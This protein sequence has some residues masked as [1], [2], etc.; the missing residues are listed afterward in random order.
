MNPQLQAGYAGLGQGAETEITQALLGRGSIAVDDN[1]DRQG[2]VMPSGSPGGNVGGGAALLSALAGSGGSVAPPTLPTTTPVNPQQAAIK[3]AGQGLQ[4][5]QQMAA[6]SQRSSNLNDAQAAYQD[7]MGSYARTQT[8]KFR[9]GSKAHGMESLYDAIA[10]PFARK[11]AQKARD[12]YQDMALSNE[13]A[14]LQQAQDLELQRRAKYVENVTPYI[15]EMNPGMT[16]QDVS[17]VAMQAA[18]QNTPVDKFIKERVESPPVKET[19]IHSGAQWTRFRNPETGAVLT[20]PQ[21]SPYQSGLPNKKTTGADSK[22]VPTVIDGEEVLIE[23]AAPDKDGKRAVIG[24]P[25]YTGK[26]IDDGGK[27]IQDMSGENKKFAPIIANTTSLVASA[28]PH[29]FSENGNWNSEIIMSFNTPERAAYKDYETAV[30]QSLRPESGATITETEIETHKNLY[31]P[32]IWDGDVTAQAKVKRFA[33]YQGKVYTTLFTGYNDLQDHPELGYTDAIFPWEQ[34]APAQ[35]AEVM[36][37][38]E[39]ALEAEFQAA[40]AVAAQQ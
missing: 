24:E 3:K 2:V 37:E 19:F 32:N 15:Q 7:A 23:Y 17:A 4:T 40:M 12:A 13:Q 21:Y 27:S 30:I 22:W 33:E 5:K 8:Q 29:M 14:D 25:I 31:L 28:L 18:I 10:S 6:R 9:P 26:Q 35:A 36:I 16:E 20:D 34:T 39:D 38:Q 1:L 11:K